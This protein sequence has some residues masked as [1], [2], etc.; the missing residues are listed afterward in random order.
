MV[1]QT[2]DFAEIRHKLYNARQ[3]RSLKSKGAAKGVVRFESKQVTRK[4]SG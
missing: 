4:E 3:G 2:E 1:K